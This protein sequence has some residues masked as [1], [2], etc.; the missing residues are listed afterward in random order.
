MSRISAPLASRSALRRR[1]TNTR[2]VGAARAGGLPAHKSSAR[3]SEETTRLADN[4]NRAKRAR[5]RPPPTVAGG[6]GGR[7]LVPLADRPR[8]LRVVLGID[9]AHREQFVVR[10]LLHDATLVD[11]EN[12]IRRADEVEVVGDDHRGLALHQ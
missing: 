9:A 5:S 11:H 2:S 3:R 12:A 10:P 4:N 1:D 7:W 8:L 6:D